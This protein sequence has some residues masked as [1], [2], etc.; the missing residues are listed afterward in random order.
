M[1]TGTTTEGHGVYTWMR[2][3]RTFHNPGVRVERHRV[4]QNRRVEL[5]IQVIGY[6]RREAIL[7]VTDCVDQFLD[8]LDL[9]SPVVERMRKANNAAKMAV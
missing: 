2:L 8:E 7:L 5:L 6:A 1:R 9:P 3:R 4:R